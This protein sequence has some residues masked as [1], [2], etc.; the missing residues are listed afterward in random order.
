MGGAAQT[1]NMGE[2]ET[3]TDTITLKTSKSRREIAKEMGFGQEDYIS[4]KISQERKGIAAPA[5]LIKNLRAR[6]NFELTGEKVIS[7]SQEVLIERLMQTVTDQ[8]A[9][10]RVLMKNVAQLNSK[11]SGKSYSAEERLIREDM[12]SEAESKIRVA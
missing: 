5:K 3:I 11:A 9:F 12:Q 10:I 7:E 6:Y 2:L 8:A 4:N 1:A